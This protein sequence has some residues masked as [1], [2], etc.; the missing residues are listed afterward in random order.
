MSATMT[1]ELRLLGGFS[2][3][4]NTE[5]IQLQPQPRRLVAYLALHSGPILR[6]TISERLWPDRPEKHASSA[7]RASLFQVEQHAR[8][9]VQS[10]HTMLALS[11]Q[12]NVDVAALAPGSH[13]GRSSDL[14][15]IARG[16]LLPEMEEEW[17]VF[18]RERCRQRQIRILEEMCREYTL[19]ANYAGA[20][21][22]GLAAVGAEP[23]R[24]SSQRALIEAHL[25]EGNVSE[26]RIQFGR[27]TEALCA[28]LGISPSVS[29]QELVVTGGRSVTLVAGP[30]F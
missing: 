16:E 24:E 3:F 26:A 15:S 18:E 29:L 17:L 2:L 28:E 12:V 21:E 19:S 5:P 22:A 23:L 4:G 25:A 10:I 8:G 7:L 14:A 6:R 30:D 20:I 13:T 27:F 1:F 11:D 9:L